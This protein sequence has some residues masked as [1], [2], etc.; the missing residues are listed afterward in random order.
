MNQY[1][2]KLYASSSCVHWLHSDKSSV[3]DLNVILCASVSAKAETSSDITL[4]DLQ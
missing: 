2:N 3:L 1:D 4:R